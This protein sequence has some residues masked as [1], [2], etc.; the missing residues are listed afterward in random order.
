[1]AGVIKGGRGFGYVTVQPEQPIMKTVYG[2]KRETEPKEEI[3]EEAA[4]EE[5]TVESIIEMVDDAAEYE[6]EAIYIREEDAKIE[7]AQLIE[8]YEQLRV[9]YEKQSEEY[10]LHAKEKAGEIYEKTK[11]MA[12]K[13]IEDAKFESVELKKTAE[14]EGRQAG[15]DDGYKKGYD[16]GYVVALKKCRDTLM[17]LKQINEEIIAKKSEIFLSYERSL[18][19]SIFEI[20]QKV[21]INSLKQKDKAVI[22][23][24]LREAG[25]RF[26]GSKNVKISLSSLDISDETEI[27]EEI[28]RDIFNEGTNVEFE[29]LKDAPEGTLIIDNGSE[30]TDAGVQTQLKMIEQLGRGKYRD[31]S[32]SEMLREQ[33]KAKKQADEEK[34]DEGSVDIMAEVKKKTAR[35]KK[36]EETT[37]AETE[38]EPV[39][40]ESNKS[41]GE[42]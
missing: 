23:K 40:E 11:A 26:R 22:T 14:D 29:I 39:T 37:E 34:A 42:E 25:K 41:E 12:H 15:Y 20:A 38:V 30:I 21:T 10:V 33:R 28:L 27:D 5:A 19:D 7:R 35:K 9:K 36:V 1:M 6:D 16:E 32:P 13:T 24:M 17:E 3:V 8:E 18:F 4:A 31:K 2:D